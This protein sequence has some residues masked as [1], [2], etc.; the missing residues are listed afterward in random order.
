MMLLEGLKIMLLGGLKTSPYL[1][2]TY[3]LKLTSSLRYKYS[4][5]KKMKKKINSV[6]DF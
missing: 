6:G 5:Y 1:I 4:E 2:Y 3:N